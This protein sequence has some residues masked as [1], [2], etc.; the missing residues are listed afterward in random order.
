MFPGQG[1]Q[2]GIA[3]HGAEFVPFIKHRMKRLIRAL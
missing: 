1:L 3:V 2:L